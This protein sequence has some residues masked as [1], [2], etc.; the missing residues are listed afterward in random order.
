MTDHRN[1]LMQKP[2]EETEKLMEKYKPKWPP[3]SE[4]GH[5]I[6]LRRTCS[7]LRRV[8]LIMEICYNYINFSSGII[9]YP[10]G[11]LFPYKG[12][13]YSL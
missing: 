5:F 7:T 11:M 12:A 13:G 3:L 4:D 10:E 6:P 2:S 9:T 8:D 1:G